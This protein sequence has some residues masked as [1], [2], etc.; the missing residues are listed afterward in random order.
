MKTGK[1]RE[2]DLEALEDDFSSDTTSSSE[3]KSSKYASRED[4]MEIMGIK[5]GDSNR[6]GL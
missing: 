2:L 6:D 3:E 4:S 5:L 1:Q